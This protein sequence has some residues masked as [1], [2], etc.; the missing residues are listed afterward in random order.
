MSRYRFSENA[1]DDL[2]AIVDYVTDDSGPARAAGVV[3]DL[4]NALE[5]VAEMPE[6]GHRREDLTGSDLRFWPV[7]SYLIV[8]K[9]RVQS[10]GSGPRTARTPE[11]REEARG[12]L[13]TDGPKL[14]DRRAAYAACR[15]ACNRIIAARS[16]SKP[17]AG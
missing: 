17:K 8:Y 11:H 1:R 3:R 15:K 5:R 10:A 14:P 6:I 13:T 7:F 4:F 9:P 12:R 2:Q 16:S